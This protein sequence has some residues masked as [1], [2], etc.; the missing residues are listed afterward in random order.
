MDAINHAFE[1]PLLRNEVLKE[2]GDPTLYGDYIHNYTMDY[3]GQ[4][5]IEFWT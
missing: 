3:V 4:N 5:I 2:G 1:D